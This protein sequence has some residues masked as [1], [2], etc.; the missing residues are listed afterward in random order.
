MRSLVNIDVV[1]NDVCVRIGDHSFKHKHMIVGFLIDCYTD[2]MMYANF[3]LSLKTEVLDFGYQVELPKDF[4]FETK[5]GLMTKGCSNVAIVYTKG[6]PMTT[7]NNTQIRD[8]VHECW[9]GNYSLEESI[10]FYNAFRGPNHL[11]ELYGYGRVSGNCQSVR[12]NKSNGVIELGSDIPKCS[13]IV[14]EYQSD[15]LKDGLKLIPREAKML[16]TY[17]GLRE[18]HMTSFSQTPGKASGFNA[19]YEDE[20]NKVVGLYNYTDPQYLVDAINASYSPTNY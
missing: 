13:K 9:G 7:F 8:C 14:V 11:G 18:Y 12:V 5:I 10:P 3:D 19:L 4:I 20:F 2:F 6:S 1:A 16:F 17:F 15:G